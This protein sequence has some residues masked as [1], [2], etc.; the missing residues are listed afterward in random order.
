MI[1]LS[2]QEIHL[3]QP[4]AIPLVVG[5]LLWPLLV[6]VAERQRRRRPNPT[7]QFVSPEMRSRLLQDDPTPWSSRRSS[8][9]LLWLTGLALSLALT[10][11]QWGLLEQTV[12]RQGLD[13][14]I[15]IDLSSSMRAEDVSP[16]RLD[17]ARQELAFLVERLKGHRVGLIGFAGSPFL[18]CPLTL[19]TDAVEMF[20]DEMTIEAVPVP[21]TAVGQAIRTA[22]QSFALGEAEAPGGSRVL[23]L[24]SDGEDH[25][26][27]PL[28]A[29]D[30]AAQAG[31]IIDTIGLG[32]A[33][34]GQIPDP[35][36]GD[37]L[38]DDSGQPV[39]S[40]LDG[41]ILE[42]V[43]RRTGGLFLRLESSPN[44]LTTYLEALQRR[45]TRSLGESVEVQRQE[46]FT[47][48]L[49]L[50]VATYLASLA[51][52]SRGQSR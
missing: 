5:I 49:W 15:A 28:E 13:V 33:A 35:S 51:L 19:D 47:L 24:L 16:S 10:R 52:D 1:P 29:A 23:L 38:R 2:L 7:A 45:Q 17:Q 25:E 37:V 42:E 6:Q 31:V 14:M 20:L 12:Q 44:G 46:R 3:A 43:A 41:R 21:G 26:S 48:F 50:A 11:P 8:A 32:T 34:G 40:R 9:S 27:L 30:E 39:V 36:T 4:W 22:L 18:F